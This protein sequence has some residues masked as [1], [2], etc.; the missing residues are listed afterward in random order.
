MRPNLRGGLT[1]F[2]TLIE[3][4]RVMSQDQSPAAVLEEILSALN[5]E[6]MLKDEGPDGPDRW[7]NVRELLAGAAQWSEVLPDEE[8]AAWEGNG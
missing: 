3:R 6:A 7:D 2:A 5:Y 1:G 8:L 4:L